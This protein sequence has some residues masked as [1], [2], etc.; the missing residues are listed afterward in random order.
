MTLLSVS[1]IAFVHAVPW[2]H[3]YV[4][5]AHLHG[6]PVLD[7]LRAAVGVEGVDILVRCFH[8]QLYAYFS[9]SS[10]QSTKNAGKLKTRQHDRK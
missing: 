1:N 3:L 10:L 6:V 5:V 9:L 8:T 2:K 4:K 7:R